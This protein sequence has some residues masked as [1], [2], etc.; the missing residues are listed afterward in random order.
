MDFQNTDLKKLFGAVAAED[1]DPEELA[2][3]FFKNNLYNRAITDDKLIILKGYKGTG[4]SALLAM[5]QDYF[6]NKHKLCLSIKPDDFPNIK[7]DNN[8]NLDLISTWKTD[9]NNLIVKKTYEDFLEQEK[10]DTKIFH[11]I[12]SINDMF[13]LTSYIKGNDNQIKRQIA[14]NFQKNKE[15]YVFIDDL[16]RGWNGDKI[17]IHRIS[18]LISALRDLSNSERGLKFR[19]SL[20][21]DMYS[22][23]RYDDSN[24]DKVS[25]NILDVKWTRDDLLRILVLRVQ[26]FL[27]K[28][29]NSE[30]VDKLSQNGLERLLSKVMELTFSGTG[31]WHDKPIHNILLSLIRERPRDLINLCTLAAKEA[32]QNKH[33]LIQTKDWEAVFKQ[34]SVDRFEDTITEHRD[35]LSLDGVQL[36]LNGMKTTRSESKSGSSLYSKDDILQK[37]TNVLGQHDIR[38][39]GE[40]LKL[41]GVEALKFLYSVG[42]VIARKDDN[43]TGFITRITYDQN[44]NLIDQDSGFKFEIH[45]AFRW[46]LNYDP[47]KNPL[48]NI[49]DELY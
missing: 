19:V 33:E 11:A 39:N 9:L 34:Y 22:L 15:V 24:L 31:K 32:G 3:Y 36:L 1:D 8:D 26:H 43:N 48:N 10:P 16:D 12:N 47:N 35:E 21:S 27:G 6:Y 42:F 28:N 44:H 30:D 13:N 20:R 5:A 7:E 17:S 29:I 14:I 18:S 46:A 23:L 4:K 45:P 25:Q 2:N 49:D 37:I 40:A 38:R 41:S